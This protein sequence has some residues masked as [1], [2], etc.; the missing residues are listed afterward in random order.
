M[1]SYRI[2]SVRGGE[3]GQPA[4]TLRAV[5]VTGPHC[6]PS[7]DTGILISQ[8]RDW[9]CRMQVRLGQEANDYAAVLDSSRLEL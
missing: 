1:S 2:C 5:H 7:M 3:E 4:H 6:R 9:G 8:W